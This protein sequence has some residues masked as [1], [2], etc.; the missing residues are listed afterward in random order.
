MDYR[1]LFSFV[2]DVISHQVISR[3]SSVVSHRHQIIQRVIRCNG[4]ETTTP[5]SAW[6][7]ARLRLMLSRISEY[8]FRSLSSP[9]DHQSSVRDRDKYRTNIR[10]YGA[11]VSSQEPHVTKTGSFMAPM[12]F[13]SGDWRGET[14]DATPYIIPH[15]YIPCLYVLSLKIRAPEVRKAR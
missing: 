3:Q 11:I 14:I 5:C 12:S 6:P 13:G 9:L 1:Y 7:E 8:F 10:C 2:V 15:F 4:G